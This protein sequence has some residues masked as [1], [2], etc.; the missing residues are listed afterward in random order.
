M[1]KEILVYLTVF[2]LL[3]LTAGCIDQQPKGNSKEMKIL[4]DVALKTTDLN[5]TYFLL[6][7]NYI[8]EPYQSDESN[9]FSGWNVT[10]KYRA[11]FY[12][13]ST[14]FIQHEIVKLQS[15]EKS[16]EFQT[17]LKS[18]IE[19]LGY[20][21]KNVD[22]DPIGNITLFFEAVAKINNSNIT[23][24]LLTFSYDDI[25]VIIQTANVLKDQIIKYGNIVLT[26]LVTINDQE[27]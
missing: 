17:R 25:V 4:D 10:Q 12:L 6:E 20:D 7:E 27:I 18:N 24:Y 9:L 23:I 19:D 15:V 2:F 14:N 1:K 5:E 22:I 8:I 16:D 21:F 13:N 3:M 11:F 26:N